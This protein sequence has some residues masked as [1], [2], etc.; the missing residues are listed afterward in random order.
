M[1]KRVL[2]YGDSNTWGY[3]PYN[4]PENK[5]YDVRFEAEV[6]WTGIVQQLLGEKYH[7]IEEGLNGR[8]TVFD[9]PFNP[10]CNGLRYLPACL[11]THEPI[12]LV[13]LMLGINDLKP[14]VC[15]RAYDIA[16]G[17]GKLIDVVYANPRGRYGRQPKVL[18]I[19]PVAISE[20]IADTAFSGTFGGAE[21]RE[22]SLKLAGYL[23]K[24]AKQ[25]DCAFLNAAEHARASTD[26][27]HLDAQNHAQLAGAVADKIKEVFF[28][29]R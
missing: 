24:I 11:E 13:V 2:C 28:D 25:R 17:V 14:R 22:Q 26:G 20:G 1:S 19:S 8:T 10:H 4:Q 15:R 18:L 7:I 5:L 6:R 9:D 21:A 29:F 16:E 27:V 3:D 12:D 23:S